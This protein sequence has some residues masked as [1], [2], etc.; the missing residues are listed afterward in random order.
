MKAEGYEIESLS[1]RKKYDC[2]YNF[3]LISVAETEL[4]Q[5]FFDDSGVKASI[6]DND[7]Y[8]GSYIIN[9]N[10]VQ[11]RIHFINNEKL[12]HI[13]KDYNEL[14]K[15]NIK[16][17]EKSIDNFYYDAVKVKSKRDLYSS[18]FIKKIKWQVYRVIPSGCNVGTKEDDYYMHYNKEDDIL[19]ISFP[20]LFNSK[21][22]D[23]II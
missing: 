9:N 1:K 17:C 11:S 3:N 20:S 5:L 21:N 15:V 4:V 16:F 23:E 14:H 22:E 12:K 19:E 6:V 13:I 8:I 7:K 10:D 18:E 2:L